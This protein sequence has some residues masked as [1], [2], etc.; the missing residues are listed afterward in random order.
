MAYPLLFAALASLASAQ[1]YAET[2]WLPIPSTLDNYRMFLLAGSQ[3]PLWAGNTLARIAWYVLIPGAVAVVCGYIFS[4]LRFWGRDAIF[5]LLISSMMVPQIVFLVPTY[6]MLARWPLAGG[7]DLYG[8][9]GHGLINQWP[10]LLL[11]GMTNPYYIFLMRQAYFNVPA[12][13]EEAARIDGANM[14]QIITA[15][16]LP[17]LRPVITVMV[18]FQFV[19][20]WN[21]YLWPLIVVGG[22]SAIWPITLGLQRIMAQAVALRGIPQAMASDPPFLFTVGLVAMI[23]TIVLYL[24]LQRYFVE[25][26]EGFA[27]KG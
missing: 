22:N 2:T 4:R 23:P 16:Y 26:V 15:I 3:L 14:R 8:Q 19:E 5:M 9:G 13:F 25:G 27:V 21:E 17:I 11:S 6:V 18:I 12:D 1:S 7:N 10:G 20:T 24:F